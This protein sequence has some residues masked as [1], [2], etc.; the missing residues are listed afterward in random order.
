VQAG[1]KKVVITAPAKGNDIPTFVVGVNAD[2]YKHEYPIVSNA[3]C[4]T[5]CLAPFAKVRRSHPPLRT[6]SNTLPHAE[7]ESP[8]LLVFMQYN[9]VPRT[10]ACCSL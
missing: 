9:C 10:S 7:A 2:L 6:C 4:T 3:S 5:N 8:V 1:A